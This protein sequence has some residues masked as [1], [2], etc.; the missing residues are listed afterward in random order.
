MASII[1][2]SSIDN[3]P[4][5]HHHDGAVKRAEERS[6][7]MVPPTF[8]EDP[9]A[10]NEPRDDIAI[11]LRISRELR[12]TLYVVAKES[13]RSLNSLLTVFTEDR[14]GELG[15]WPPGAKPKM[16]WQKG[17]KK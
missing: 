2:L 15:R 9:P 1:R 3:S 5:M 14:L 13:H 8:S 11:T 17:A 7:G 12:D 10:G 16:P 4:M 6:E